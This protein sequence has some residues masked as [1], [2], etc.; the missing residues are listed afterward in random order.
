MATYAGQNYGAKRMDRVKMGLKHGMVMTAVFSL[1]MLIVLQLFS[2]QIITFFVDDPEVIYIGGT[3]L[4]ITSWLYIFLGTIY[5]TRGILNGVGDALFAFINGIVEML[6]RIF[7][8]MLLVLIPALGLWGIW[9]TAG[10]T[11]FIS[12]M[13]CLLRYWSWRKKAAFPTE[14]QAE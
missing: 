5:M 3:A 9:W 7:L 13:F 14:I 11:W 12:A 4:K 10:L 2:S 1:L 8:P 6:C